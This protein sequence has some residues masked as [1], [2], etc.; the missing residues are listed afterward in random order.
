MWMAGRIKEAMQMIVKNTE[1]IRSSGA[2]TLLL[3]CPIC[4]RIFKERYKLDGIRI[5][6]HTEFIDELISQGRLRVSAGDRKYV[7]HDPCELGRGCGIYEQPRNVLRHAG[8][9]VEAAK[10]RKESICC[11]GSVGSLSLGL[12]KRRVITENALSNLTVASPDVIVTA[13][14]L[15]LN[16]F[17]RYADR[18]VEDLAETVDRNAS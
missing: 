12:E 9:L 3:T 16:T 13:C 4:Y 6:H 11:G 14:P 10:N 17:G 7:Y 8:T 5:V 18:K 15:C 1:I 2:G